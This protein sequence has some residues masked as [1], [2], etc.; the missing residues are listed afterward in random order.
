MKRALRILLAAAV[1]VLVERI[2]RARVRAAMASLDGCDFCGGDG[3]FF[4]DVTPKGKA[5]TSR[6][7]CT[8]CAAEA[9]RS[10]AQVLMGSDGRRVERHQA[11]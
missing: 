1:R 10:G 9:T 5:I 6:L 4:I 3:E 8:P 7:A 11:P 2:H